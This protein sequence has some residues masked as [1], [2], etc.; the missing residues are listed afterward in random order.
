MPLLLCCVSSCSTPSLSPRHPPC[1]YVQ[2]VA[3]ALPYKTRL[4]YASGMILH[5]LY[6]QEEKALNALKEKAAKGAIG[7]A[8]LKKSGKK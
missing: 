6:A 4:V 1:L 3:N 8:G 5:V 7:G 2:S